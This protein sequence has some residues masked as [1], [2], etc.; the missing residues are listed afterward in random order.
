MNDVKFFGFNVGQKSGFSNV[1][2]E[3]AEILGEANNTLN[4]KAKT[5][6]G[7]DV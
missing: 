7:V 2:D 6:Y 1:F 5:V 4:Y 3:Q